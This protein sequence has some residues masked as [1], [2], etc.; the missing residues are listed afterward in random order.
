MV[1]AQEFELSH[2]RPLQSA[3]S[4]QSSRWII[5]GRSWTHPGLRPASLRFP[6]P[7]HTSENKVTYGRRFSQH[8]ALC[9]GRW[10]RFESFW[11]VIR[12]RPRLWPVLCLRLNN[13]LPSGV[14]VRATIWFW[15]QLSADPERT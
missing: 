6:P 13:P 11:P 5:Q 14:Q 8:H 7:L 15:H 9:P 2:Y 12:T 10:I 4:H 3:H 1:R